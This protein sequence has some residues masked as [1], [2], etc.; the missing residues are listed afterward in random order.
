MLDLVQLKN[1]TDDT[2]I[3]WILR[4]EHVDEVFGGGENDQLPARGELGM[5][6]RH[7]IKSGSIKV[8]PSMFIQSVSTAQD[9]K[10]RIIGN[11]HNKQKKLENIDEIIANTGARPNFDI[12]K[13]L[14]HTFDPALEC[15]PGLAELIDPN[16]HSCGTVR[17]H[18]EEELRQPEKNFYIIG[19][20][21]YGRAPSFLL[22]T[23]YEQARSVAAY[24]TGDKESAKEVKLTLPE[25]GVCKLSVPFDKSGS[26]CCSD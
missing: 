1:Q 7:I 24:I 9:G 26:S 15:V 18:G 6:L 21:S 20:K 19:S 25:T 8:F 14:R 23:G 12:L 10:L 16:I 22:A 3:I 2:N 13:E 4:K 11:Q 5:K 17:P